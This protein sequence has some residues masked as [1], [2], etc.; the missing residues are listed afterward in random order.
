MKCSDLIKYFEV[1]GMQCFKHSIPTK[2]FLAFLCLILFWCEINFDISF[3]FRQ[4]KFWIWTSSSCKEMQQ[5]MSKNKCVAFFKKPCFFFLC[6]YKPWN[7]LFSLLRSQLYLG[8][9]CQLYLN[10]GKKFKRS[11]FWIYLFHNTE[12]WLVVPYN[13]GLF[14]RWC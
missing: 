5:I 11:L 10:L 12:I 4:W 6:Y 1:T 8:S 3:W 2:S 14:Y 9:L 13:C 7:S